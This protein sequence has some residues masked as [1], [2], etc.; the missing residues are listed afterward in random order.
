[1]VTQVTGRE[2]NVAKETSVSGDFLLCILARIAFPNASYFFLA[3]FVIYSVA[4]TI[5]CRFHN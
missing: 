2:L 3:D 1:M 5:T 4:N